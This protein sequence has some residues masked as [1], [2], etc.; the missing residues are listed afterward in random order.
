[1][2]WTLRRRP[3][4]KTTVPSMSKAL[5]SPSIYFSREVS[6][7]RTTNANLVVGFL[8]RPSWIGKGLPPWVKLALSRFRLAASLG[9]SGFVLL[10]ENH[11]LSVSACSI[12]QNG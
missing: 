2:A 6:S 11:L 7:W 9:A 8:D 3:S 4:V 5:S 10:P 12:Q 1:M